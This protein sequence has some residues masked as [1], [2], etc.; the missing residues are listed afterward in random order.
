MKS[1]G[2]RRGNQN[3]VWMDIEAKQVALN[4]VS[5][6]EAMSGI[7]EQRQGDLAGYES[8]FTSAPGQTGAVF[9]ITAKCAAWSCSIPPRPLPGA[10]IAVVANPGFAP[11]DLTRTRCGHEDEQ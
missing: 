7:Y 10:L 11:L 8:A 1:A 4:A 5:E 6:T 3:K 2:G 9:V